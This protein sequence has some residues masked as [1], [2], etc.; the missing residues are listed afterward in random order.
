MFGHFLTLCMK[1]LSLTYILGKISETG[2]YVE[3]TEPIYL[4]QEQLPLGKLPPGGGMFFSEG[5]G[6]GRSSGGSFTGDNFQVTDIDIN[7]AGCNMKM[8]A[9]QN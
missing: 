4:V 2:D 7:T 6:E 1:K 5:R 8:E 3:A 9:D